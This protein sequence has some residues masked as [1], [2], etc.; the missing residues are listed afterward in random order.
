M[1]DRY[2]FDDKLGYG[3]T[4]YTAL[5]AG[6]YTLQ[7]Q[8]TWTPYDVRDYVVSVYAADQILI[9]DSNGKTSFTASN[10]LL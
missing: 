10:T 2:S 7:F 8:A 5:A 3:W 6:T 1:L 4:Q 9:Y